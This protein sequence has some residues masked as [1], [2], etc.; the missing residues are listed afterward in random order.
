MSRHGQGG[1]VI[2]YHKALARVLEGARLLAVQQVALAAATGRVLGRDVVSGIALPP[3]DNAAMDGVALASGAQPQAA[4]S[5][6]E[7][8]ARI[9][10]GDMPRDD[11]ASATTNGL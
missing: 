4:G 7:L 6:W 9:G 8:A 2:A 3:F 10:A 11:A 1:A 5:E